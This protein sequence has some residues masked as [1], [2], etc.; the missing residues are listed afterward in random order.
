MRLLPVQCFAMMEKYFLYVVPGLPSVTP[1]IYIALN[2]IN[3]KSWACGW[4]I[5]VESLVLG[6]STTDKG[7]ALRIV[8]EKKIRKTPMPNA[9]GVDQTLVRVYVG[10]MINYDISRTTVGCK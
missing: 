1:I 7:R 6:E 8:K 2:I 10:L 9:R 5:K 3:H 4:R